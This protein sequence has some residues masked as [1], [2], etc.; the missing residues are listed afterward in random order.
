MDKLPS[1]IAEHLEAIRA[2]CV[3]HHIKTL[4]L[5]GSAARGD[6]FDP[7]KSDADFL[8]EFLPDAPRKPWA[9]HFFR[10]QEALEALLGREVD[11]VMPGAI[12]NPYLKRSIYESAIPLYAAA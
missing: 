5:F 9:G 6:D 2:L 12:V 4:T 11:L 3:E 7:E 8:V 10:F 1:A